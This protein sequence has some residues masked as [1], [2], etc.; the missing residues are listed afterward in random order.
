MTSLAASKAPAIPDAGLLRP[1]TDEERTTW[2]TDG[3]VVAKGMIPMEWVEYLAAAVD[4]LLA[5]PDASSQNY[6]P[7]G[8][9]TF[10]AQAFPSQIDPAFRAWA[11]DG[12]LA[13]LAHQALP[14]SR[15]INFFY[16]QVFVKTPGAATPT[17]WHQDSPFLPLQGD[18]LIRFWLPLDRVTADSGALQY[19]KGSHR[20]GVIYHPLG[21]KD[22]P[23]ITSAYVESPFTDQPD[24]DAEYD[25]H[26]WLIG[27]AE[28]GDVLL[29]HPAVV[30]GARGNATNRYRRA[31]TTFYTGE[32]I[33]W[34]PHSANMFKNRSLTG[35]VPMPELEAG[36]PLDCDL[37]PRVWP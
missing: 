17:P 31:V 36:G 14:A 32:G 9:A 1:L 3:A 12:P 10:F 29:H 24:F 21:F 28:P 34:W 6:A 2:E 7:D 4:R 19:L 16:D 23:E 15:R 27:E 13:G 33:T 25:Q 8:A 26:E 35:H 20:W 11:I 22:I 18:D 37:F 30:H 5:K